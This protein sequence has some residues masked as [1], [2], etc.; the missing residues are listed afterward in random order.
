LLEAGAKGLPVIA[1]NVGGISEYVMPGKNGYMV[2][3][4]DRIEEYVSEINKI[5]KNKIWPKDKIRSNVVEKFSLSE[6]LRAYE[7]ILK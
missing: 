1:P 7:E 5:A 6:V 2:R 3:Q 4:Y